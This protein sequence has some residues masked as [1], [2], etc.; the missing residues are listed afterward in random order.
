MIKSI[1]ASPRAPI[2]AVDN[3]ANLMLNYV[4]PKKGK[5]GIDSA[6]FLYGL[7]NAA[8]GTREGRNNLPK[9]YQKLGGWGPVNP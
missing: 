8:V 4:A 6:D 5:E 1:I 3:V 7:Y 2:D 9:R